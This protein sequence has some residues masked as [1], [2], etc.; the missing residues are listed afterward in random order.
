MRVQLLM[1][2]V[3]STFIG[4]C[5]SQTSQAQTPVDTAQVTMPPSYRFD[6]PVI[7]VPVGTSVSWHNDDHFTHSVSVVREGFPALNLPP[8]QSGSITFTQAGTYDYICTYHTQDM[9]GKVIVV[10]R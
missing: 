8:G 5:T 3:L 6:P 9:K 2:L 1:L 4:G 7:R 10:A